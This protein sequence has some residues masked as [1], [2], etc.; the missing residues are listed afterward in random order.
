MDIHKKSDRGV[1]GDTSTHLTDI[2][3]NNKGMLRYYT[4]TFDMFKYLE[5][6]KLSKLTYEE[7]DNLNSSTFR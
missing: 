7:A 3:S 1:E 5:R 2:E 6:H 4:K